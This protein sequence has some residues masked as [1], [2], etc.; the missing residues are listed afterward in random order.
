MIHFVTGVLQIK[1]ENEQKPISKFFSTKG[2]KNEPVLSNDSIEMTLTQSSAK[3]LKALD[4]TGLPHSAVE[5]EHDLKCGSP[6]QQ[7]ES[8]R[9]TIL[10]NS[11]K[12][13][14]ETE[15]KTGLLFHGD[16]KC[17]VEE[18]TM[19]PVKRGLEGLS[20]DSKPSTGMVEKPSTV[21]KKGKLSKNPGDKQPTLFSYFGKS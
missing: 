20:T 11:L 15:D 14:P 18:A 1:L 7:E 16:S 9:S 4:S 17:N 8:T 12:L 6:V 3:E 10:P 21:A 19:L 13:E 2:V 5:G